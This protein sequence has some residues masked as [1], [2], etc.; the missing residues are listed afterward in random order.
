MK[1]SKFWRGPSS[2]WIKGDLRQIEYAQ[3]SYGKLSCRMAHGHSRAVEA[4]GIVALDAN[5]SGGLRS[6]RR[7]IDP[8]RYA[9][10]R[11]EDTRQM[12]LV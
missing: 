4:P 8:G 11:F 7:T 2:S 5:S 1:A 10:A 12:G 3:R 6:D 9:D